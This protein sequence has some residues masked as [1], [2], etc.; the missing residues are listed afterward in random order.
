MFKKKCKVQGKC[1]NLVI[2]G[3]KPKNL[4]STEVKRKLNLKCEPDHNPYRVSWL[5]KDQQVTVTK[6]CLLILQIGDFKE[7]ALFDVVEMD[8]CHILLGMPSMFDQKV[9]HDGR[10]NSYEFVQMDMVIS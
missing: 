10:K 4:V 8:V 2:D 9:F 5:Q 1:C 7:Q 3:G 6:Q